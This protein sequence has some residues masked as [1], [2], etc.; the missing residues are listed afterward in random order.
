MSWIKENKFIAG[1][2]GGTLL[3]VIALYFF[4][5]QGSKRY[6]EAKEKY[7]AAAAEVSTFESR[8]LYPKAE[9][10]D[11][12]RKALDEYRKSVDSIQALFAPFR[13]EEL[14]NVS[15]QEFTDNLLAATN[16]TRKAF[17]DAG[18]TVPEAYF[19]GFEGY[20][21]SLAPQNNTGLLGYQLGAVKNMMLALAKSG[22]TEL[23]NLHRPALPE[24]GGQ[25][26]TPGPNDVA[27]SFPLEITFKGPEK[28]VREFL[29]A[30]TKPENQF[31]VIRSLRITNEKKDP[32]RAEDAKFD[33][34]APASPA[35]GA[36]GGAFSGGF[37]LP[38]EESAPAEAPA[39]T[40]APEAKPTGSGR[41]LAPV[42]GSEEVN[43]FVRLD[44][45]QFLPVKKLP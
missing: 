37:V 23:K 28:S 4:G 33:Q 19:M 10:R 12:K 16:E 30:I 42:L 14:K 41:I 44:V 17:E 5:S 29:S 9:N 15:P 25:A 39:A 11:G 20:R 38:G 18:V 8:P 26:Y 43:V 22:P 45:L 31:A 27:R 2:G 32:P 34:P 21:S 36:A 6:D 35:G 1:L 3:G 7:D 24:E 40:P 13:P